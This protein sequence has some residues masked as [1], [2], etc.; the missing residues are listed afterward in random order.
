MSVELW[1]AYVAAC[2]L[3]LATPGPTVL[4][5]VSY[6]VAG[7]RRSA[8][9]TVPAVALGDFTAMV[10]SLAGLGAVMAA[11]GTLFAVLKWAGAA[12]LVYLGIRLWRAP[13]A[14]PVATPDRLPPAPAARWM[15][16]R[17]YLVTAS[18]PKGIMFFVAFLPQF[19]VPTAPLPSQFLLLGGTFLALATLNAALYAVLAG[20][21]RDW[22]ARPAMLRLFNR[23]GGAALVG[24]GIMTAGLRRAA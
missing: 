21:A 4:L 8:W 7:G 22:M 6:A 13:V 1:L 23:M 5:V 12:Y 17:V 11:S 10:L 15:A 2:V 14:T 18:N 3:L 24:A 20:A 16:W 9:R 19:V